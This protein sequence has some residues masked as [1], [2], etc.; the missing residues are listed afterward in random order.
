MASRRDGP[1][2]RLRS[3]RFVIYFALQ[4]VLILSG[5]LIA[6]TLGN[7]GTA[8][9]TSMIATGAGGIIV[10]AWVVF[11]EV[12]RERR[13]VVESFGFV[14]AFPYRSIQIKDEY[15]DRTRKASRNIDVM[16]Y[17]LNS[18]REDF[19]D[20]F[21][22]WAARVKVRILLVDVESPQGSIK[23]VDIRDLEEDNPPGRTRVE[24]QRFVDD[25]YHL[26]SQGE[27]FQVRLAR[28]LPSVNMFR[29]DDESFWGPYLISSKR[30]GRASRNLPTMIVKRPGYMYERLVDHFDEIW[31]SDELSRAPG[32]P[33]SKR[34]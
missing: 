25:T 9:G 3:A 24:V 1:I 18:L 11:D 8:V 10:F 5:A 27:N 32:A 22:D 19:L 30:Y 23:Y 2:S 14:T 15:R 26:W 6:A 20:D 31:S 4:V 13:A 33:V 29:I 7:L 34:P 28:T 12:E 16:G 17:G 21:E